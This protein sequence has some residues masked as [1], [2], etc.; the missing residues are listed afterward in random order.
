MGVAVGQELI[1]F[2]IDPNRGRECSLVWETARCDPH[3]S[4]LQRSDVS[5]KEF[6][7]G[8]GE[9][10]L[11]LSVCFLAFI[12]D[13]SLKCLLFIFYGHQIVAIDNVW[14]LAF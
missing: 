13:C 3:P 10:W 14:N 7:L 1:C 5:N 9:I 4:G 12:R 8:Q 6:A 11:S 2:T